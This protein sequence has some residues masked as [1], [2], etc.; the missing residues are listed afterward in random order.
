MDGG[1][2]K[3]IKIKT[4][5]GVDLNWGFNSK[6]LFV[7]TVSADGAGISR[8]DL[9]GNEQPIWI[10]HDASWASGLQSPD[11]RHLAMFRASND[12]NVWLIDDF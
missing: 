2:E 7:S 9:D 1:K 6:Y 3:A 8:V 12:A 11:G 5:T 4:Y 10:Q